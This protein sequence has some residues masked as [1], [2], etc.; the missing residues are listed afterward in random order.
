MLHT[1]IIA[2]A[3]RRAFGTP[4]GSVAVMDSEKS[5]PIQVTTYNRDTV[6]VEHFE[7]APG[8]EVP[9][10][11]PEPEDGVR[12]INV[13]GVHDGRLLETLGT[14]HG[15]HMLLVEDIQLTDQRPKFQADDAL[16]FAIV[17]MISWQ[18]ESGQLDNEQVSLFAGGRTVI[19]FQEKPGDVFESIRERIATGRGRVRTAGAD[20]LFYILIDALVDSLFITVDE[21]QGQVEDVEERIIEQATGAPLSTV[22]RIR[23]D[24]VSIRRSVWPLREM[25]QRAS[26][27]DYPPFAETTRPFLSDGYD[28]VLALID[29]IDTQMDRVSGLFQLHAAMVGT[30]TNE[31]TRVLTIIATIFIPLTFVAG[32]YGMNFATMPELA[33][34]YGYPAVLGV[35]AIIAVGMVLY[36]KRRRWL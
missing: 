1:R 9:I 22:H 10:F 20:Y 6:S 8:G 11:P 36:F 27:G 5:T 16:L 33:W 15:I 30:S 2:R 13:T 14:R 21:L 19:S 4:P 7:I 29:L 32:I 24:V 28:H 12:W 18:E 17:R 35:M 34:R 26:R 3:R 25:L 31:I 23:S